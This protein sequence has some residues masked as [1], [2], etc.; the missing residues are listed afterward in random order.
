VDASQPDVVCSLSKSLYGLKQVPRAWFT[1]F[2]Q[3]AASIAFLPTRLDSSGEHMVYLLLYVDD[4]ILTASSTALLQS[5]IA[6]L[7]S[8]FKIKDMGVLKSFLGVTI[9]HSRTGFFLSQENYVED[10]LDR[11]RMS[12]CKR[13]PQRQAPC[14]DWTCGG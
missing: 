7:A 5:T 14:C 12:D 11:V 4:I 1:R 8:E 13:G 2:A 10:I 9:W 6:K 3:F